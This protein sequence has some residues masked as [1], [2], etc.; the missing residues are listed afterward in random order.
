MMQ[1][2]TSHP[3]LQRFPSI[4]QFIKFGFVGAL[5]TTID[6]LGFAVL[7]TWTSIPYLIANVMTFAIASTNSYILNRR[8]TFRNA[9]PRWRRQAAVFYAVM[10]VGLVINEAILYTLVDHFQVRKL[11]AKAIGIVIV[12]FWNFFASR[13]F[14]FR[15]T[16]VSLPG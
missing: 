16:S 14:V 11:I 8:W 10:V 12:L 5:N 2:L 6:Y 3:I 9:D 4:K 15:P 7:V 13:F 1:R